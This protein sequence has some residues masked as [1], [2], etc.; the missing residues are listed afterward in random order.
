MIWFVLGFIIG[1]VIGFFAPCAVI[2]QVIMWKLPYEFKINGRTYELK[3]S[4]YY[5]Q[6]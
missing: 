5:D 3:E 2:A 6:F 1:G 4:G